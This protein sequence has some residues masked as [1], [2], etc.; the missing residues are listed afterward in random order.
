MSSNQFLS[1]KKTGI[2]YH[3]PDVQ[4]LNIT[5]ITQIG[6]DNYTEG[7]RTL[8]YEIWNIAEYPNFNINVSRYG[9]CLANDKQKIVCGR[10]GVNG[11]SR[12]SITDN[13]RFGFYK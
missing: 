10:R 12:M 11:F 4:F 7:M 2:V 6:R 13:T 5:G 1:V 9:N 3:I 8:G